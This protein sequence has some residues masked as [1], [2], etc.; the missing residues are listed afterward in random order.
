MG[1]L[2]SVQINTPTSKA[3][4]AILRLSGLPGSG[5]CMTQL[6]KN[7]ELCDEVGEMA[8]PMECE[9]KKPRNPE[10]LLEPRS[11]KQIT[12]IHSFCSFHDTG[13]TDSLPDTS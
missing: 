11:K 7:N 2:L 10:F 8:W 3:A 13:P 4:Q 1:E 6:S 12:S 5:K 9:E